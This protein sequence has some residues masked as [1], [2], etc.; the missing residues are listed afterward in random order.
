MIA[1]WRSLYGASPLHLLALA[2]SLAISG[3]AVVRWFDAGS[4][5]VNILVWFAGALVGHDLVLLPLYS[6]LDRLAWRSR[7]RSRAR[8]ETGADADARAAAGAGAPGGNAAAAARAGIAY[9]RVPALL[10]GLLALVFFPLMLGLGDSTYHAASARHAH[11][12]LW[13]W[14][15]IC[16]A[17]FAL[18]ALAFALRRPAP[19][20]R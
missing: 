14:L 20:E 13:R 18:S 19:G 9:V 17:L 5:T 3:A 8:A 12:Y 2:A 10:S 7:S 16:G 6:A 4:D 1:R 15:A 11:G